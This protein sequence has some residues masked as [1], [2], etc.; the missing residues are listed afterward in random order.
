MHH[1]D[2]IE[3]ID[4][5]VR[6]GDGN[7]P[8]LDV[9]RLCPEEIFAICSPQLLTGRNH[10]K[11]PSDVLKWPLL[12][13]D[14]QRTAWETWLTLAGVAAPE[15]LR[16]PVLDRAS[17]IIDAAI[18]GQGIALARTTLAAWDLISRRIVGPFDVSW[19][20]EHLLDRVSEATAKAAKICR[21]RE[22]L[23]AE[24]ETT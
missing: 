18:D 2:F 16:G 15:T 6:H 4:V 17:L 19:R 11:Q 23:L 13:L 7:W 21:F 9:T 12:R 22:W 1:A 10:L 14:D 5:A 20:P 3:D 24:A 8:G